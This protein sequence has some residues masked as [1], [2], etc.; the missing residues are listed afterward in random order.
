MRASAATTFQVRSGSRRSVGPE[1]AGA[2]PGPACYGAGGPLTLTDV[3][4][5]L[6]RLDP[7]KARIPLDVEPSR[8]R[9]EELK[10][11]MRDR[12]MEVPDDDFAKNFR[13]F[14]LRRQD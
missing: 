14:V 1:S 6:G 5:L 13:N 3:N 10:G 8:R 12:N 9:L 4:F 2:H 11:A 7:S